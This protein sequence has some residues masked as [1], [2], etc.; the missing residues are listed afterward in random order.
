MKIYCI[1]LDKRKDKWELVSKHNKKKT[2]KDIIR[3]SGI[4]GY[5]L[6]ATKRILK[7]YK[8]CFS[9]YKKGVMNYG[10]RA[11]VVGCALSHIKTWIHILYSEEDHAVVIE[12]DAV[13]END[14]DKK[15]EQVYNEIGDD[16]WDI[17]FLGLHPTNK[18][19]NLFYAET[20]EKVKVNDMGKDFESINLHNYGAF[21]Y[22]ISKSACRK[23]LNHYNNSAIE[24]GIDASLIH[25]DIRRNLI[26]NKY[27]TPCL[28]RSSMHGQNLT[29]GGTTFKNNG[30]IQGNTIFLKGM[31]KYNVDEVKDIS[32]PI[33][34]G[35]KYNINYTLSK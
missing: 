22:L 14:F 33:F 13:L 11:G 12:D 15:L 35:H 28:V 10:M 5:S 3:V 34:D 30:N 18:S 9:Q 31:E 21:G 26:K 23:I 32:S 16:D 20:Y 24:G 2:N 29:V 8:N 4:D 19:V 27:L 6:G 7:L 17:V 1:N 25:L